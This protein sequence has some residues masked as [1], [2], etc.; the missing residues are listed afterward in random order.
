MHRLLEFPKISSYQK[1]IF[2]S[3]VDLSLNIHQSGLDC[4]NFVTQIC[5][6]SFFL[7]LVVW[8][9]PKVFVAKI[10]F[11][12]CAAFFYISF[13]LESIECQDARPV[14]PNS[15]WVSAGQYAWIA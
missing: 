7:F 13:G 2:G 8:I 15:R 1:K 6:L 9:S 5:I 3:F 4:L 10:P 11:G 14:Q 12:L